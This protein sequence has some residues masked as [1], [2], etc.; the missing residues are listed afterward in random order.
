MRAGKRS[1]A[2]S[3]GNRI[4]HPPHLPT[5]PLVAEPEAWK[6]LPASRRQ[7]TLASQGSERGPGLAQEAETGCEKCRI[8]SQ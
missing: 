6:E 1:Q 4:M 7:P 8:E 5:L 2:A 3:V